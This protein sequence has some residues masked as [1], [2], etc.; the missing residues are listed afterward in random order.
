MTG[1]SLKAQHAW[2]SAGKDMPA[3][4]R[5]PMMLLGCPS[6]HV[7]YVCK[8]RLANKREQRAERILERKHERV[9]RWL[10]KRG[11]DKTVRVGRTNVRFNFHNHAG[12][13]H[14]GRHIQV[15]A[16]R[17]SKGGTVPWTKGIGA[18]IRSY[19]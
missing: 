13:P 5:A 8:T 2:W 16:F 9:R 4:T 15:N 6:V 19:F 14:K 10:N 18:S 12:G 7:G 11:G 17:D 3:A 1:V